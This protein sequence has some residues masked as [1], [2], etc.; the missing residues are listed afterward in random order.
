MTSH[1]RNYINR[2][3][4]VSRV[5]VQRYLDRD[6]H[7]ARLALMSPKKQITNIPALKE[8]CKAMQ[9]QGIND[10]W[11]LEYMVSRQFSINEAIAYSESKLNVGTGTNQGTDQEIVF[12]MSVIQQLIS[13]S[14]DYQV[15]VLR[16]LGRV[17][18]RFLNLELANNSLEIYQYFLD[19]GFTILQSIDYLNSQIMLAHRNRVVAARSETEEQVYHEPSLRQSLVE[20]IT[21]SLS[22]QLTQLTDASE[23]LSQ[24]MGKQKK[25]QDTDIKTC[26]Y[27]HGSAFLRCAVNPGGSCQ[28]CNVV[29]ESEKNIVSETEEKG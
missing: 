15:H 1:F 28:D 5:S 18:D 3:M 25:D 6:T 20:Q 27:Y 19:E 22:I 7:I 2:V 17:I 14:P 24:E 9:V 29:S 23:A 8:S 16:Y 12:L 13:N 10:I 4:Q 26:V 21:L 11:T